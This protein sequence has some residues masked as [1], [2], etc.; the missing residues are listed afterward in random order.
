MKKILTCTFLLTLFFCSVKAQWEVKY[1]G[2]L[3]LYDMVFEDNIGLI[4]SVGAILRSDDYGDHWK[5]IQLIDQNISIRKIHFVTK[6]VVLATGFNDD[7]GYLLSSENAGITW[8]IIDS[9]KE[10][11]YGAFSSIEKG[12]Y[13]LIDGYFGIYKYDLLNNSIEIVF[14]FGHRGAWV[15]NIH[16]IN[17]KIGYVHFEYIGRSSSNT[18][19][20]L[21]SLN[22]G[23]TWEEIALNK[24]YQQIDFTGLDS[25]LLINNSGFYK[26]DKIRS[27]VESIADFSTSGL[28]SGFKSINSFSLPRIGK[29][30]IAGGGVK[31]VIDPV[32]DSC[33]IIK[34]SPEKNAWK[35][36]YDSLGLPIEKVHAFN[37]ST[38]VIMSYAG[39]VMKTNTSGGA[40]PTDYPWKKVYISKTDNLPSHTRIHVTISPNPSHD[41]F[42]VFMEDETKIKAWRLYNDRGQFIKAKH[43]NTRNRISI[44]LTNNDRGTY[45]LQLILPHNKILTRKIIKH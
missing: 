15:Y 2:D 14:Y 39:L 41:V 31:S 25:A 27:Q 18:N 5:T 21:K 26:T 11:K 45:L 23:D 1:D 28:G 12:R 44:D 37:D 43:R 33:L 34:L 24:H 19:Y 4:A 17:D 29:I 38:W 9:R 20:I 40:F 10:Y 7:N 32:S 3:Y 8:S 42:D 16:F 30:G 13:V 36:L 6:S 22:G 35:I